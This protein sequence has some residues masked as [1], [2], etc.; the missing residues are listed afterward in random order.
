MRIDPLTAAAAGSHLLIPTILDKPSAEAVISFCEEV[1]RLKKNNICPVLDYVGVV[2]ERVSP[3]VDEIA[4]RN[5]KK[6]IADGLK[7]MNFPSGLVAG[8]LAP[9]DAS[10]LGVLAEL[11]Y[12]LTL[13][14]AQL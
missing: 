14:V 2:G 4:E 9:N 6:M 13:W 11:Y 10:Q 5:A 8:L 1:E 12:C 3:N 7:Q